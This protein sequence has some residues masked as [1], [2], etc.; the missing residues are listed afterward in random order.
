MTDASLAFLLINTKV[1]GEVKTQYYKYNTILQLIGEHYQELAW[2]FGA[3]CR[4]AFAD[5]TR[6]QS[7]TRVFIFSLCQ[8]VLRYFF[9]F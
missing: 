7:L 9:T 3:L 2:H 1:G 8:E 6:C 4:Q 5:N